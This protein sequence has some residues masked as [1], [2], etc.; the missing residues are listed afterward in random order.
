MNFRQLFCF[1]HQQP[2]EPF[3]ECVPIR[4]YNVK[5]SQSET[6]CISGSLYSEILYV[7][8]LQKICNFLHVKCIFGY[9]F[10]DWLKKEKKKK[11]QLFGLVVVLKSFLK[12]FLLLWRRCSM[13]WLST[14]LH[15]NTC[16][17]IVTFKHTIC[18]WQIET[19][20]TSSLTDMNTY[21]VDTNSHSLRLVTHIWR[22]Y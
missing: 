5:I 1:F 12:S 7:N 16:S 4:K 10:Q 19:S 17:Y 9:G 21:T 22:Y 3:H 14:R 18:H 20:S 2:L 11:L 15:F 6:K 13:W 8:L